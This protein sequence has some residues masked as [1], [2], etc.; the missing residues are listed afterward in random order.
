ME[1]G[2]LWYLIERDKLHRIVTA[3]EFQ[4][5]APDTFTLHQV[6]ET[7]REALQEMLRLVQT[8]VQEAS[9]HV[10]GHAAGHTPDTK[11]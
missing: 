10:G 11:L 7:R 9:H 6:F 1:I 2:N 3:D 5:L 4:Q 8:A